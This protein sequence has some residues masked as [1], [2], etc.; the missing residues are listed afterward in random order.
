MALN[1]EN[2]VGYQVCADPVEDVVSRVTEWLREEAQS[3]HYFACLNPHSA[4]IA[5]TDPIFHKALLNADFLTPDGIGVVYASRLLGG[6]L[7]SRVTGMDVFLGVTEAMNRDLDRSCFFLGSSDDT[8]DRIRANITANFPNV[9]VAGTYSPPFK[10]EFSDDDNQTMIRAI[11]ESGASVLWVGLTAPK[12]ERW[13]FEHRRQLKVDFAG[14]IGGAFDFYVGNIERVGQFWQDMGFE[15]LPR[16]IQEPR[17]LWRRSIISAPRFF[18]SAIKCRW[19]QK[20][21]GAGIDD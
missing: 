15:W 8:L 2:I 5:L 21:N 18:A 9:R 16:L 13:I 6:Q 17:R 12:Q 7:R 3:C 19:Q 10:P 11:N 20:G 1:S 14:P 4:E